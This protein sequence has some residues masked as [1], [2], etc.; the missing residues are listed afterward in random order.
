[1]TSRL[2]YNFRRA[3]KD[4]KVQVE[5]SGEAAAEETERELS[6]ASVF[7][8]REQELESRVR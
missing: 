5:W 6:C 2:N 1:V 3:R 8:G 4:R 7:T